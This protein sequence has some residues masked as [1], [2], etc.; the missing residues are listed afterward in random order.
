MKKLLLHLVLVP[1]LS[2]KSNPFVQEECSGHKIAMRTK[3]LKAGDTLPSFYPL[4]HGNMS[5]N[6]LKGKK[7][8]VFFKKEKVKPP[9]LLNNEIEY[10]GM[11]KLAQK[12]GVDIIVLS[13]A[14]IAGVYG[15]DYNSGSLADSYLFVA[16]ENKVIQKIYKNV[17]EEDII[18]F[19]K[20]QTYKQW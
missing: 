19:L 11:G 1:L 16:E 6:D 5:F 17:C 4:G 2:C 14:K 9:N 12:H 20:D 3:H 10:L 15:V 18:K 7:T 8:L 13:D